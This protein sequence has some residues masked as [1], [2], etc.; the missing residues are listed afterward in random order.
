MLSI[1]IEMK[2]TI[3]TKFAAAF[4]VAVTCVTLH[5]A[6]PRTDLLGDPATLSVAA[7]TIPINAG[8]R[9]INVVGGETIQFVVGDKAFAW[10]F[11]GPLSV[12]Q[13]DLRRVAP[14]G[15]LDHEVIAYVSPNPRLWGW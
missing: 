6:E 9:Y 2:P 8:T 14:A 12:W 15:L 5:A 3:V 4:T 7:R 11:S 10:Y 13:F 1:D